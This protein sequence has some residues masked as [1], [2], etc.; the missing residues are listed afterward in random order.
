MRQAPDILAAL[1]CCGAPLLVEI[2]AADP[3]ATLAA[4]LASAAG[5]LGDAAARAIDNIVALRGDPPR[6]EE[7][8]RPVA[9]GSEMRSRMWLGGESAA[10][11]DNPRAAARGLMRVLRPVAKSMLPDPS[12]L[13]V[14]NA[15]EMAHLAGFLPQLHARFGP[16]PE[17]SA[18]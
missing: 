8:F 7:E 9:G 17:G 2:A 15:Q 3:L 16:Q 10:L 13:L 18:Q 14:H 1:S 12:E 5:V 6:G 4:E 11:G